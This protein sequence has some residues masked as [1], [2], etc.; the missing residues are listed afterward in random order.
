MHVRFWLHPLV[1]AAALLIPAHGRAQSGARAHVTS[2]KVTVLS[3]MLVGNGGPSGIGEWGFAA[4]LE[5][6]GRRILIDTG[7]RPET[8]LKNV[9]EMRVDLSNVTDVVLTHNHGD[10]TGGLLALRRSVMTKNPAALSRV[11]VPAGIFTSRV[12]P[13]GREL[14]G[15]LPIKPEFEKLGGRFIEH[16][17]PF[18]LVPGAW[19]LGPVPRVHPE[20]NWSP[21]GRLQSAGGP[22]EDN[23]PEDTA[24]AVNTSS[25]L[26][27]ISGCG[28]AGIINTLEYA[29]KAI[30][31]V[32]IEAA[33]GG[34]HLFGASDDA[35]DWTGGRLKALGVRNLLGAHCTGI[36]AVFR[37]RQIVGLARRT[38]VVG[39]VGS[40]FTLGKGIESPPLAR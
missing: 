37:L 30:A 36:E 10:H 40:S 2:V 16:S 3:T 8:V 19:L 39:A 25:G 12:D 21:T 23:I 9:E 24:I 15:L 29:R 1:I 20:R 5:A 35:L 32:A 26:V 4:L 13:N 14:G 27:V 33:I 38:A 34:F 17:A 6:D 7:A 11:H 18:E 31:D 28:H 22:V